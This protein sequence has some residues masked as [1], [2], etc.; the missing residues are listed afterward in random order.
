VSAS[1]DLIVVGTGFASSFFLYKYLVGAAPVRRVLVL[2]AGRR[3]SQQEQ[4]AGHRT[5]R[6]RLEPDAL[7]HFENRTPEKPWLFM[8]G[9]GGT[10]NRWFG[11]APRMQPDDFELFT[12]YGVG[13]DWPFGYQELEPY[14]TEAER[15][16]QVSGPSE[17]DGSPCP[18]SSPYPQPPHGMTEPDR[19]LQRAFPGAFFPIATA[20]ARLATS[21]RA[22]CCANMACML[23]PIDAK[24]TVLNAFGPLYGNPRVEVLTGAR[25]TGLETQGNRVTGVRFVREGRPQTAEA[26]LVALGANALFNAHILLASGARGEVTGQGL[27]EQVSRGVAFDLRGMDNFQGSTSQTG[28]GYMFYSG[29]HRR[30]RAAILLETSNVPE[31]RNERGKWRHFLRVKFIAEDLRQPGNRVELSQPAEDQPAAVFEGHSAYADRA[32]QMVDA[33]AQKIASVLPVERY[34][35]GPVYRSEAHIMGTTVMGTDPQTSVVDANGV[36]HYLRNLVVLG[37][38][39]FPT[40]APANPTL[41]IAATALRAAARL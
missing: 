21:D 31:L 18:R 9:F 22:A 8:I 39:T 26:D 6:R 19:A 38:S 41:T 15:I 7:Q 23:C 35:H 12:R 33:L 36:H 14:Y 25:V 1:Y 29:E 24:F 11:N 10:S 16:M 5:A 2:E 3:E 13:A 28:H 32:L 40:A 37:S 27:V 17:S 34:H 4:L 20:R 30:Q